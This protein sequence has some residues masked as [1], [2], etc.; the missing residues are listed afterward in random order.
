MASQAKTVC[1]GK[2]RAEFTRVAGG[3]RAYVAHRR[4][5]VAAVAVANH[6]DWD[7]RD[8]PQYGR[9]TYNHQE[10]HLVMQLLGIMV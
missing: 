9:G 4:K 6:D 2:E 10:L 3:L 5:Y 7:L 1:E 8:W